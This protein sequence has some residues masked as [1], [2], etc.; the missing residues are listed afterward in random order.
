MA[1][2]IDIEQKFKALEWL[3][4]LAMAI[5]LV[6]GWT[7]MKN[8]TKKWMVVES[9]PICESGIKQVCKK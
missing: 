5:K 3:K 1:E 6:K 4:Q 7:I 8:E 2:Y 9:D